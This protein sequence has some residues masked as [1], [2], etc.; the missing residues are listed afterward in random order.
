MNA[1]IEKMT[2][3]DEIAESG[4]HLLL[5]FALLE[6]DGKEVISKKWHRTAIEP[7]GSVDAQIAAVNADITRRPELM[8]APVGAGCIAK[9]KKQ[10]AAVH[11]PKVVKAFREKLIKDRTLV[12]V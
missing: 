8:A 6:I 4:G 12:G 5:R 9:I 11:T 7:G 10:C 1:M 2:V 3:I